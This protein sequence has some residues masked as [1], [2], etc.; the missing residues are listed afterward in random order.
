MRN[1]QS[2]RTYVAIDDAEMCL[3]MGREILEEIYPLP[4]LSTAVTVS[5]AGCIGIR[6]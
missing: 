4:E 1:D 2:R 3:S 6:K 5:I